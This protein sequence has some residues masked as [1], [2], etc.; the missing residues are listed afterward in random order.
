MH[1]HDI[2]ASD[3]WVGDTGRGTGLGGRLI[4]A[5]KFVGA[6]VVGLFSYL[7]AVLVALNFVSPTDAPLWSALPFPPTW[8]AGLAAVILLVVLGAMLWR[9]LQVLLGSVLSMG[10]VAL[11][12]TM[13]MPQIGFSRV[14]VLIEI[15]TAVPAVGALLVYGLKRLF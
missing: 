14:I 11:F 5:L 1:D 4:R 8:W 12:A 13:V 6:T 15:F 10:G 2:F 7:F 3:G 9:P